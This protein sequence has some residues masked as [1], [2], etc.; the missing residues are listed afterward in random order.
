MTLITVTP[1]YAALLTLLLLALSA[2]VITYRLAGKIS[3]GDTGDKALLKRMRVQANCAE[4]APL[5]VVLILLAELQGA[6]VLALHAMGA[7]LTLGRVAHAVGMSRT[8]QIFPLRQLGMV[9][10]LGMMAVS[11]LGLL[12]H[13]IF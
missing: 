4:Y 7:S 2:R 10:T 8:P 12:G 11:A 9:L 3:L 6:P 13:A 5:G 1:I